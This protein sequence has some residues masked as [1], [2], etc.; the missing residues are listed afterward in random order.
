MVPYSNI[1]N[2]ITAEV[3]GKPYHLKHLRSS[4]KINK[5]KITNIIDHADLHLLL[6][7][8]LNPTAVT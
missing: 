6:Q 3:K 1:Q 5:I 7:T 2:Y 4:I 8:C